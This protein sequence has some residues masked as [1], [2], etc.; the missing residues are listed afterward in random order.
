LIGWAA[1]VVRRVQTGYIYH[2]AFTMIIGLFGLMTY[3][4]FNVI[5]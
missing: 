2:Y 3:W 4:Y 1:G 5:R